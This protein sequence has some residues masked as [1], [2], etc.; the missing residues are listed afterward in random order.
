MKLE[1]KNIAIDLLLTLLTAGIWNLWVQYRQMK[2]TNKLLGRGE[3]SPIWTLIFAILTFG[4]YFFYHEY[5]L[6]AHIYKLTFAEENKQLAILCGIASALGMWFI[7]DSFQQHMLNSY[8]QFGPVKKG[9]DE[10][11]YAN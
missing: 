4:I 11:I 9:S 8:I 10:T 7:V 6:T 2:Q 1:P 3:Y 5:K